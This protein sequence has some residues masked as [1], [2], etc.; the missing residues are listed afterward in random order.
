MEL[1]KSQ[2]NRQHRSPAAIQRRMNRY[3]S[4]WK[5]VRKQIIARDGMKCR[6]CGATHSPNNE[7]LSVHHLDH[8]SKNLS[9]NNLVT[10]CTVCHRRI[11]EGE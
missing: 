1:T 7:G 4:N 9:P 6:S 2:K 3:P 10:L 11:H 5:S 8:N